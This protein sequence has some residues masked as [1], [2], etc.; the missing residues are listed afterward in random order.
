MK[1]MNKVLY[2][3]IGAV[4]GAVLLGLT[5]TAF[6]QTP[7]PAQPD[8]AAPWGMMGQ[9]RGRMGGQGN[10]GGGMMG[11]GFNR[12]DG[13]FGPMHDT[14]V[15]ALAPALKLSVDELNTKLAA[16]QSM[17]QI[18]DEQGLTPEEFTAAMTA[19]HDQALKQAVTD[20]TL[21]QEQADW[22]QQR[23]GGRGGM[24]GRGGRGG[25]PMLPA[26]SDDL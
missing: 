26:D 23:M 13:E 1:H 6:A 10:F 20:G 21:T 16:G 5:V 8:S 4:L 3:L 7:Q 18:A 17:A 14:M 11:R 15:A 9:G 19:A 2:L 25:C 12:A 24:M 22:M